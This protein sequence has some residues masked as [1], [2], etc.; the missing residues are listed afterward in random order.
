MSPIQVNSSSLTRSLLGACATLLAVACSSDPSSSARP[1]EG[2]GDGGTASADHVGDAGTHARGSDGRGDAG[3]DDAERDEDDD[4]DDQDADDD[5]TESSGSGGDAGT[6]GGDDAEEPSSDEDAD[7]VDDESADDESTDAES[8]EERE[9]REAEEAL[10][11]DDQEAD[12]EIGVRV[13]DVEEREAREE[14]DGARERLDEGK[15]LQVAEPIDPETQRVQLRDLEIFGSAEEAAELAAFYETD[16]E[17]LITPAFQLLEQVSP[18]PFLDQPELDLTIGVSPTRDPDPDPEPVGTIIVAPT[19]DDD[20]PIQAFAPAG[21]SIGTGDTSAV[22]YVSNDDLPLF[23]APDFDAEVELELQR[24]ERVFVFDTLPVVSSNALFVEIQLPDRDV[25]AVGW[26]PLAWLYET[27]VSTSRDSLDFRASYGL[28][29]KQ[30]ANFVD[31]AF[32]AA[33]DGYPVY[34]HNAGVLGPQFNPNLLPSDANYRCGEYPVG[35]TY[36]S[37]HKRITT[38][39][40]ETPSF[41]HDGTLFNV[42][43]EAI[44]LSIPIDMLRLDGQTRGDNYAMRDLSTA[45]S[46]AGSADVEEFRLYSRFPNHERQVPFEVE[47][48]VRVHDTDFWFNVSHEAPAGVT[49]DADAYINACFYLPGSTLQGQRVDTNIK[50]T[51]KSVATRVSHITGIEFGSVE[52]SRFRVCTTATVSQRADESDSDGVIDQYAPNAMPGPLVVRFVRGVIEDIDV[53]YKGGIKLYGSFD[54]LHGALLTTATNVLNDVLINGV[55]FSIKGHDMSGGAG[56]MLWQ[57]WMKGALEKELLNQLDVIAARLTGSLP[58]PD[59]ALSRACDLIMPDSYSQIE[60]PFYPLYQ[61]CLEATRDVD[62]DAIVPPMGPSS[63]YEPGNYARVS[64][65]KNWW[66]DTDT[67]DTYYYGD[68]IN[69]VLAIDRPFWVNGCGIRSRVETEVMSEWWPLLECMAEV[70]DRDVNYGKTSGQVSA[71]MQ[72]ECLVPAVKMLCDLYGEGDDLMDMWLGEDADF[73]VP[74]TFNFCAYY[75]ELTKE[76]CTP[77]TCLTVE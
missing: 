50:L 44:P 61:Q 67:D 11:E 25:S 47:D 57:G 14:L 46:P 2:A 19:D 63:C 73:D 77:S 8:A 72:N 28:F 31:S 30:I 36:S 76:P 74:N 52:F 23:S 75:E 21:L 40:F 55:P 65:G 71:N 51:T 4:S 69:D 60:S 27:S 13:S 32:Y 37:S 70:L 49:A 16:S 54:S 22:R 38:L 1:D 17:F 53:E 10:F 42:N 5:A 68:G 9:A 35:D 29:S 58:D 33:C 59:G 43:I 48:E 15:R 45:W 39:D 7:E 20:E 6:V 26:V 18:S 41:H 34:P 56:P 64:D 3:D 12:G 62:I 24:G 66:S